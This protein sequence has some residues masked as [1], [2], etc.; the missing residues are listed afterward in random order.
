M[1][2]HHYQALVAALTVAALLLLLF[3]EQIPYALY[4][5]MTLVVIGGYVSRRQGLTFKS[6]IQNKPLSRFLGYSTLLAGTL[7]HYFEWLPEQTA[8]VIIVIGVALIFGTFD[9][10]QR[11]RRPL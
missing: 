2:K 1:Q 5:A 3:K 4:A 8:F 10:P 11:G 7:A 9:S 6:F